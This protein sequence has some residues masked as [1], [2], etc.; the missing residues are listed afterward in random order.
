MKRLLGVALALWLAV[1]SLAA[2]V[3][4]VLP[5][6]S[7]LRRDV[8][9]L[10]H[11][12]RQVERISDPGTY[13][14]EFPCGNVPGERE[15]LT[16]EVT[17][18]QVTEQ[19]SDDFLECTPEEAR[20][21][22]EDGA[23]RR[24]S[25]SDTVVTVH[26]PGS[27]GPVAL[28]DGR[29]LALGSVLGMEGGVKCLVPAHDPALA[30]TVSVAGPG[31]MLTIRGRP[32]RLAGGEPCLL[33]D[34]VRLTKGPGLADEP[35]W[36]VTLRWE[37]KEAAAFSTP[38]SYSVRLPCLHRKGAVEGVSVRLREFNVVDL[39]VDGRPVVAELADTPDK[40]S[41]GL[42][43]HPGLA[44]DE[45]MLFFFERPIRPVF[46]MKAV[47]FPISIAFVRTDGVIVN[48][49]YLN[50]GDLR[51]VTSPV[52]VAY[53]LEMAQGWF[54]EHGVAPGKEVAIP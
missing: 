22:V 42:Q 7:R 43:G 9:V 2:S 48:I 30:Q 35:P 27:A 20:H 46:A 18:P 25:F 8:A 12:S 5:P 50:P 33:V 52:P 40:L 4:G 10:W 44:P 37:G 17:R 13:T 45:G 21:H 26:R 49:E 51:T 41:W 54:K 24:V 19:G 15:D 3:I 32:V 23:D 31:D 16:I 39:K 14:L 29:A 36:T 11:S 1:T 28:A 6:R 53:V 38:G 34:S 47:S